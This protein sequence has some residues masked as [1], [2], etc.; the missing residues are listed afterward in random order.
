MKLA[1]VNAHPDDAEFTCAATIKQAIDLGWDVLEILMTSDEYG[2]TR[3]EFKGKRIKRIRVREMEEAAKV[4]GVH[5]DGKPKIT[6]DWFGAIDGHLPFTRAVLDRLRGKLEAFGPDVII[7]PDAF[8]SMDL[9]PD[10]VRTGWL[11]YLAARD[12]H[13]GRQRRPLVLLYHTTRPDFFVPFPASLAWIQVEAWAKHRSQTSPLAVKVLR[14][15]RRVFY[16][17]RRTRTG[18]VLGEGFRRATFRP[19]ENTVSSAHHLA[20]H[21]I[22][23]GGE[24][25]TTRYTPSPAELGIE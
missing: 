13:A 18:R 14:H 11:V 24:S 4:Y 25:I 6:L 5:P 8:F 2:T 3:D 9:H 19:G 23:A 12:M 17:L 16:C 10:H 1:I 22:F 15:A 20:L 7:G 21:H